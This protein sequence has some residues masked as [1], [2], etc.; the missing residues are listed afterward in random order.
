MA[1][2]PAVIALPCFGFR[3]LS[4]KPGLNISAAVSSVYYES[5]NLNSPL[6]NSSLAIGLF[7]EAGIKETPPS[8]NCPLFLLSQ[9]IG[10]PLGADV[11]LRTLAKKKRNM[12]IVVVA[13]KTL[14]SVL[15]RSQAS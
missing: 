4:L 2:V 15:S 1:S 5:Q 8:F 7:E 11:R 13:L 10:M 6:A 3:S 12:K 9:F 14:P